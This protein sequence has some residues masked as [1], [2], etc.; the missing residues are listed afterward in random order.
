MRVGPDTVVALDL[1]LA[2]LWGNPLQAEER[3]RYLHGHDEI[4]P[5]LERALEGKAAGEKLTLHR[6]SGKR[7]ELLGKAEQA[8]PPVAAGASRPISTVTWRLK[9]LRTGRSF[10]EVPERGGTL[11]EGLGHAVA[12]HHVA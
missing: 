12:E 5:A 6:P 7:F 9:A 2:D 4:L 11:S 10:L 3:I 1:E 8:V